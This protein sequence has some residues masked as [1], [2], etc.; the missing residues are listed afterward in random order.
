[1]PMEELLGDKWM[2]D[3]HP[4]DRRKC[5]QP[6]EGSFEA[7]K[8]FTIEYRLRGNDGKYRR[9]VDVGVPSFS[10]KATFMGYTGAAVDI[11]DMGVANG[12]DGK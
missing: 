12:S 10:G 2:Q 7:K 11:S 6:Y 1:M 9:I 4:D 5:L 3:V 8:R